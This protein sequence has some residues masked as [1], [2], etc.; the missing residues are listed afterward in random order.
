MLERMTHHSESDWRQYELTMDA[1]TTR[2]PER[3]NANG[4]DM[5]WAKVLQISDENLKADAWMAYEELE[6]EV[7]EWAR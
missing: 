4:M 3:M 2:K 1:I 6:K 7:F 5:L